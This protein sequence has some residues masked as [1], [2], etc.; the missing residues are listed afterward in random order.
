MK[1][2]VRRRAAPSRY[3]GLAP[4][5]VRRATLWTPR[6]KQQLL[7]LLQARDGEREPEAAE[8]RQGLPHRSEAEIQDFLQLLKRRVARE[9]I[10]QEHRCCR[11]E[12]RL[13]RA[14]VPAPIEVWTDLATKV[15]DHLEEAMTTAF[16]QILTIAATEPGSL[17][18]SIPEKPTQASERQLLSKDSCSQGELPPQ[19]PEP[20]RETSGG[21]SGTS[22][23]QVEMNSSKSSPASPTSGDFVIDFEKI[24]KYLSSVSR[25]GKGLELSPGEAAVLLDLL[26]SLPEE[27][28]RLPC[29]RLQAHMAGSYRKLVRPQSDSGP[30]PEDPG[31]GHSM[32]DS[33]VSTS[34]SS[35]PGSVESPTPESPAASGPS[36][37]PAQHQLW[38]DLEFCP[39]NPFLVPLEL[40]SQAPT[41][42]P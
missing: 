37:P 19:A 33:E 40:L 21:A 1:P 13:H 27:L 23:A 9:V 26:M 16:S 5:G 15:T 41:P 34:P 42:G 32:E 4:A 28:S 25:S 6:E 20:T 31:K 3:R 8:L 18:H 2:P 22:D 12:P 24:Y 14:E 39:L 29:E 38:Q 17:L 36:L 11:K 10:Q 35:A 30:S 7:R